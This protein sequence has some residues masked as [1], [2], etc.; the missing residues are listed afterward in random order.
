[1]PLFPQVSSAT[2]VDVSAPEIIDEFHRFQT[3]SS[4]EV[5]RAKHSRWRRRYVVEYKGAPTADYRL[6]RDFI[7]NGRHT[8]NQFEW[9]HPTALE[10]VTF[11]N[12]TPIVLHYSVTHGLVDGQYIGVF[13][14]PNS[15]ARNGFWQ[16]TR[17]GT[18]TVLLNGST[19]GGAGPGTVRV[20]FPSAIV[21]VAEYTMP[22]A[23]K[24]IGPE[25][26]SQ[27]FWTFA[28]TVEEL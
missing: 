28:V 2:H 7:T 3:E 18:G 16:I 19:A 4:H 20:Y 22:S 25:S 9:Y 12:T 13:S 8:I 23:T 5:R 1:M 11:D 15:N 17:G 26:G 24:L 27:G 10:P 6:I 21:R 14:S